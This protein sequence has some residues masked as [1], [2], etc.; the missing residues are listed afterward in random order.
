M[1][2]SSSHILGIDLVKFRSQLFQKMNLADEPALIFLH[3]KNSI[4]RIF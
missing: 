4:P 1:I 2:C 3:S